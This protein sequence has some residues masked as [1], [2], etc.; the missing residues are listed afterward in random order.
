M[1]FHPEG[2]RGARVIFVTCFPLVSGMQYELT[3][4]LWRG[5]S[6]NVIMH[7]RV[8]A[9]LFKPGKP[10]RGTLTHGLGKRE[11]L[12]VSEQSH[13]PNYYLTCPAHHA[14]SVS[15]LRVRIFAPQA[16]MFNPL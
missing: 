16:V 12:F 15:N 14:S 4:L 5:E 6:E 7:W 10:V 8:K 9:G 2:S 13:F 11:S 1:I 3:Q